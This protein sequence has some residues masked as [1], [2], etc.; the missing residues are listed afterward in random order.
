[1]T[2]P[3]VRLTPVATLA[4]LACSAF[5]PASR[6]SIPDIGTRTGTEVRR[7]GAWVIVRWQG[8]DSDVWLPLAAVEPAEP[9]ETP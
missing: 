6:S 5:R 4:G 2:V 7:S 3:R 1:L 8:D 9:V